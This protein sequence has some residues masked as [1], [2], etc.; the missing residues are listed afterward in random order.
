GGALAPRPTGFTSPAANDKWHRLPWYLLGGG[1]HALV[2]L[3][4]T[5]GAKPRAETRA[6]ITA[7]GLRGGLLWSPGPP[8][9]KQVLRWHMRL[10]TEWREGLKA[11]DRDCLLDRAL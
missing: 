5:K 3:S 9:S 1:Y 11:L 2:R 8:N 6:K 10:M 7:A 4:S